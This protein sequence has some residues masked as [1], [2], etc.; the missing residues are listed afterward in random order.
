[1][2]PVEPIPGEPT[3]F[4]VNS[5]RANVAPYLVDVADYDRVGACGCADF[6]FHKRPLLEEGKRGP[7]LRCHHLK[8]VRS[9]LLNKLLDALEGKR[10][11]T[12]N[13]N[14]TT[15]GAMVSRQARQ[16]ACR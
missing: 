7:E 5:R 16:Q 1:M 13:E 4:Y 11:E 2:S 8:V 14:E 10:N 9:W 3:R 15:K 6:E 12:K